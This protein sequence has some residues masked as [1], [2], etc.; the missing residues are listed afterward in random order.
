MLTYRKIVYNRQREKSGIIVKRNIR[1]MPNKGGREKHK[2][3]KYI[4]IFC[5]HKIKRKGRRKIGE[6]GHLI[7]NSDSF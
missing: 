3:I 5:M 1:L 2:E 7:S 4:K 6:V